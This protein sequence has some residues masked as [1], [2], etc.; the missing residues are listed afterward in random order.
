M[1]SQNATARSFYDGGDHGM[2]GLDLRTARVPKRVQNHY[3][4]RDK[5]Q[6]REQ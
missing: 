6:N 4:N 3:L 2:I 5:G 1:R